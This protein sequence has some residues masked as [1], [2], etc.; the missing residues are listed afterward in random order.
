MPN[1]RLGG[2]IV[3]ILHECPNCSSKKDDLAARVSKHFGFVTRG[4]P[5]KKLVRKIGWAVTHLRKAGLVE[6]YKAKNVRIRLRDP[7]RQ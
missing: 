7:S 1:R 3:E 6:E 2:A 5:R 4:E